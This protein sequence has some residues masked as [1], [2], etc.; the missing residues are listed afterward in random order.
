MVDV[1]GGMPAPR[2]R[3]WWR[4]GRRVERLVKGLGERLGPRTATVISGVLGILLAVSFWLYEGLFSNALFTAATTL[5]IAA[6]LALASRRMLF[7]TAC[8]TLLVALITA[9]SSAKLKML[10][11]VLHAY[12]L[13][14][15]LGYGRRYLSS[16]T[17]RAPMSCCTRQRSC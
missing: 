13:V 8:V 5:A 10:G 11:M 12:D 3:S 9:V 7:A 6:L 14:F 16:G 15:Y 1:S 4:G 2:S 17:A